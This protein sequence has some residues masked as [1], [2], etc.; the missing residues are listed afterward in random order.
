MSGAPRGIALWVPDWPIYAACAEAELDPRGPVALTRGGDIFAASASARARGVRRGL[1]VREAQERCPELRV[2][3]YDE[4]LDHRRFEPVMAA[5]EHIVPGIQLSRPGLC[6]LAARGP[7]R[8]YGG[9]PEAAEAL[10]RAVDAAPGVRAGAARAGIADGIFAAQRAALAPAPGPSGEPGPVPDPYAARITRIPAG[11]SAL[12]L[13][14]MGIEVLGEPALGGLLRRLGVHTLADFARLDEES[15]RDR[16][17]AAGV[18]ARRIAAGEDPRRIRPRIAPAELG[19]RVEF[20]EPLD[21][22]DQIAFGVRAS[23]ERFVAALAEEGLVAT[24]IRVE[25]VGAHGGRSARSW[26]HPRRL[27]AADVVD[28]VRWQIQGAGAAQSGLAEPVVAVAIEPETMEEIAAHEP[29]LWGGG[30][31]SRVHNG[32]TRLQGMVGHEGVLTAVLRGGRGPSER[33][34]LIPWGDRPPAEAGPD[35]APWPGALPGRPPSRLFEPPLP[36]RVLDHRGG[37]VTVAGR[38]EVSAAPGVLLRAGEGPP[39]PEGPGAE[40]ERLTAWAGPWPVRER[41]WAEG[42]G[43]PAERFQ[44]VDA[45][46]RGWLAVRSGPGW[47][48]EARYD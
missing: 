8:Y 9:E 6:L 48:I 15:V 28:R 25:A 18:Q 11:E 37:E 33:R 14:P 21:R 31:D 39:D 13:G 47:W 27:S 35:A 36:A 1:R 34:L 29:G 5:L 26:L 45:G 19:V 32:L 7:S 42:A 38:G 2:R 46:G 3:A 22:A 30:P 16:F 43:G 40:G 17:G 10:L 23:A 44:L 24:A 12:F 4:A 20:E 41:W